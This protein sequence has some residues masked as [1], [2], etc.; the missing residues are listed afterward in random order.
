MTHFM[1]KVVARP[2]TRLPRKYQWRLPFTP[3]ILKR[4][5]RRF[6]TKNLPYLNWHTHKAVVEVFINVIAVRLHTAT[7]H[8]LH[9]ATRKKF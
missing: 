6:I 3:V 9:Q 1:E 8:L 4:T 2:V 5:A 7:P